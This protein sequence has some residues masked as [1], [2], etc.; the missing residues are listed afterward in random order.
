MKLLKTTNLQ[1]LYKLSIKD[2]TDKTNYRPVNVLALL[3]K[4]FEK[5]MYMQL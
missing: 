5:V 3:S 1:T 2:P 4:I